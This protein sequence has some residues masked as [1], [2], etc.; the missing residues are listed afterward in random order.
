MRIGM[1]IDA[2]A[3]QSVNARIRIQC[4]LQVLCEQAF[5]VTLTPLLTQVPSVHLETAPASAGIHLHAG[6]HQHQPG[7]THA[8]SLV[9]KCTT[10]HHA[11][12]PHTIPRS[13]SHPT[14]PH[15]TTPHITHHTTLHTTPHTTHYTVTHHTIPHPS[16]LHPSTSSR[17]QYLQWLPKLCCVCPSVPVHTSCPHC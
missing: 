13:T 11:L 1:R 2:N 9:S 8:N 12:L 14:T 16:T 15:H 6:R 4:T 7:P 3:H 10:L 17:T 5:K